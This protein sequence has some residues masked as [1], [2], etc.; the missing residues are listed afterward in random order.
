M[1]QTV[2]EVHGEELIARAGMKKAE[3]ARRMGIQ[4]QNV[5]AL[6]RSPKLETIKRV[7]DVLGLP[8]AY[9]IG[10]VKPIDFDEEPFASVISED[11]RRAEAGLV[12][13]PAFEIQPEE[14]P[15]G[16][17]VEDRRQRQRLIREFYE[18]WKKD[19]PGL[20]VFNSSLKDYIDIK[21]ISVEE[22][23]G[24]ASLTYLST[25]AVFQLDEILR[26]ATLVKTVQTKQSSKNQRGFSRMLIMKYNVVGIGLVKLTVGVRHSDKAKVQYCITAIEPA[27]PDAKTKQSR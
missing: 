24:H 18:C 22:T 26:N 23:A 13:E 6:F 9:L 3:F 17:S 16:N 27:I 10:Y 1:N 2:F 8:L 5:K 12:D 14:V 21:H 19:H 15:T 7:A 25:L 11:L 20:S 4:R